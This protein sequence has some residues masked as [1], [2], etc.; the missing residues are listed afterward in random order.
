MGELTRN[1]DWS[2]TSIG[3]PD[4][5]PVSLRNTVKMLLS[6]KFPMFLWCGQRPGTFYNDAY[7]PSLGTEGKHPLI[8]KKGEESW[9]E[10]WDF[11]GPLIENV[12]KT[13][14]PVWFED[15]LVPIYRNGRME[16][17][18]WTFSYSPAHT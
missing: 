17:V 6:S 13:G 15:Q 11:A 18:Y 3:P 4:V 8:G 16:D 5:W 7:R 2:S 1:F 14:E 10:I 12:L 9:V